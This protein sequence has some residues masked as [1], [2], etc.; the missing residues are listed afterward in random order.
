MSNIIRLI[1]VNKIN[2]IK[3]LTF[4]L[5]SISNTRQ[6]INNPDF[7]T[8]N[9]VMIR[10]KLS[11]PVTEFVTQEEIDSIDQ[12]AYEFFSVGICNNIFIRKDLSSKLQRLWNVL[13][14]MY[15]NNPERIVECV[16]SIIEK[17]IPKKLTDDEKNEF[18]ENS[19]SKFI[20]TS[21]KIN[22]VTDFIFD[23]VRN[24]RYTHTL[25][26]LS[27]CGMLLSFVV[28]FHSHL[29]FAMENIKKAAN[30][31]NKDYEIEDIF[32]IES[33]V[34]QNTEIVTDIQAI[35]NAVSHGSFNLEFSKTEN[36]YIIDFQSVLSGYVLIENTQ[37][38]NV[39]FYILIMIN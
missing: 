10:N 26:V 39:F 20:G 23:Q 6:Y 19:L 16:T 28:N 12:V 33:K 4:L 3:H 22:T 8:S 27:I 38:P 13:D 31:L 18:W 30:I 25:D 2:S 34:L 21:K 24:D 5:N 1:L 37:V 36:E 35:R 7:H 32:S 29:Y 17:K 15:S 14:D 11:N 9:L